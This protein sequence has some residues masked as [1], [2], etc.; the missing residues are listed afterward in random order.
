MRVIIAPDSFKGSLTASEVADAVKIGINRY[1]EEIETMKVP[2]SD[3][4]E[5]MVEAL[6]AATGGEII[7]TKVKDPLGRERE[8][9]FGILGTGETAVVEMAAASGLP[10]LEEAEYNPLETTTYGTGQLIEKALDYDISKLIIGIGGSATNDGG[11]GMAQAL[12][13][14]FL[15]QAGQEIDGT[16]AGLADLATVDLSDLDPRLEEIEIEVAC[17]VDNPLVGENGA[18]HI[19]APQKGASAGDVK[20]LDQNLEH[21]ATVIKEELGQEVSQQ[22]GAG[23]AGGLGAGLLTFLD[24]ELNSGIE[25]VS[26]TL[27]LGAKIKEADLVITGEGALDHQTAN[28]KVPVGVAKVAQEFDVPVVAIAGTVKEDAK[29]LYKSGIDGMT[30]IISA[31]ITLQESMAQAEELIIETVIRVMHLLDINI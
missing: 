22:P 5:G 27:N 1:D 18:A 28:G 26:E 6:V 24:A 23:A 20:R 25:I 11:V 2:L 17:D 29:Q 16:G 13:G 31:P 21:L 12:G 9:Y 8:S 14:R 15:D 3:G 10:L 4:G 30:S 19:Y 7:E